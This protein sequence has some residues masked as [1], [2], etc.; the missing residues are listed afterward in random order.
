MLRTWVQQEGALGGNVYPCRI[1]MDERLVDY[2]MLFIYHMIWL[3]QRLKRKWWS[4]LSC[5]RNVG[6]FELLIVN[7]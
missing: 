3:T 2:W 5:V 6:F 1:G 4:L 7:G